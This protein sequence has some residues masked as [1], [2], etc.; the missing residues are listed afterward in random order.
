MSVGPTVPQLL[1]LPIAALV[2]EP[3]EAARRASEQVWYG[4]KRFSDSCDR[5]S[6]QVGATQ[7]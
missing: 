6:R 4:Y 1:E 2:W 5:Y 7:G 3:P